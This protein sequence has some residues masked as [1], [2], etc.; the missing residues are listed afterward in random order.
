MRA[1]SGG[2][3]NGFLAR[4][5]SQVSPQ[6]IF[7]VQ[8]ATVTVKIIQGEIKDRTIT[9]WQQWAEMRNISVASVSN[10]T[11]LILRILAKWQ[12]IYH[13]KKILNSLNGFLE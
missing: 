12:Q 10:M 8:T 7:Y 11:S 2:L 13:S 4:V 1:A 5:K 6:T 3:T 9:V